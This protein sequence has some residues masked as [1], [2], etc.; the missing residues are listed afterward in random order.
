MQKLVLKIGGQN[1]CL[2]EQGQ[3]GPWAMV[4]YYENT[5]TITQIQFDCM[6]AIDSVTFLFYYSILKGHW[7]SITSSPNFFQK[8]LG[9]L[10][11]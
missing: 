1:L 4:K 9:F 2:G 11:H 5:E 10:Y 7:T 6:I 3:P 8:K